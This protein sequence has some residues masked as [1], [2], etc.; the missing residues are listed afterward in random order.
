MADNVEVVRGA[1][2]AFGRGDVGA[3]IE[4][5]DDSVQWSSPVMLPQG[6]DFSGKGGVQRFF[7]GL[8]GA[9]E[10]L[11]VD[12]EGLGGIGDGV[13]VAVVQASG[14]LRAGGS[15]K[16]AAA[17]VFTVEDGKITRFREF[18]DRTVSD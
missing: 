13:V 14:S 16:Y 10:K 12:V 3:I 17:H 5:V 6:G 11:V 8:G 7:E 4:M 2:D 9:W 1:Y 15:G 18:V